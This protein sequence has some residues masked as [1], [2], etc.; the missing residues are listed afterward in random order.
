MMNEPDKE[1]ILQVTELHY[2]D[3]FWPVVEKSVSQEERERGR[4][5][6]TW[7]PF[8]WQLWHDILAPF[9]EGH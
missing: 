5:N 8:P 9:G 1:S 2:W 3:S 7:W 4:E 6:P